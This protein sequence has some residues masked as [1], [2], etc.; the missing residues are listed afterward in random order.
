VTKINH[1]Y[2]VMQQNIK[3]FEAQEGIFE[4]APPKRHSSYEG[5][6][7]SDSV[8]KRGDP[9]LF[10]TQRNCNSTHKQTHDKNA[11]SFYH[12]NEYS[13]IPVSVLDNRK[14]AMVSLDNNQSFEPESVKRV[15][16]GAG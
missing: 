2:N 3:K 7:K 16:T 5:R 9:R 4:K 10:V 6:A 8:S 11:T 15:S 12:N 13:L 1:A 14:I